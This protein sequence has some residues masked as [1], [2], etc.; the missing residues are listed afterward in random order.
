MLYFSDHKKYRIMKYI[1]KFLFVFTIILSCS[2]MAK[3]QMTWDKLSSEVLNGLDG[4]VHMPSITA[5]AFINGTTIYYV[6]D[7]E[8]VQEGDL[9]QYDGGLPAGWSS[10]TGAARWNDTTIMLFNGNEYALFDLD[11]VRIAYRGPFPN[12]PANVDAVSNWGDSQILFFSGSQYVIY[13]RDDQSV[14]QPA[15]ITDF[16]NY[17][18][19]T[20]DAVVNGDDGFIYFFR[21]GKFQALEMA[22]QSFGEVVSLVSSSGGLP[23][24]ASSGS[25]LPPVV[26]SG[27]VGRGTSVGFDDLP[28]EEKQRIRVSPQQSI[29]QAVH[30]SNSIDTSGWCLVGVPKGNSDSDL[31]SDETPVKGSDLGDSYEDD[32]EVGTRVAEIRVW[33]GRVVAALQTILQNE[34]GDLVELP[35]LGTK[36]GRMQSYKVPEGA[37]ITGVEGQFGGDYGRYIHNI[38][39][40]TS[41]GKSTRIGGPGRQGFKL[42]L[43]NSVSFFGFKVHHSGNISG[44][45]L[46]YVGYQDN[47]P[48][49]APEEEEVA[50]TSNSGSGKSFKEKFVG[51]YDDQHVDYLKSELIELQMGGAGESV[52][53]ELP[54]KDWM[55]KAVDYLTLDPLDIAKS[56]TK[57]TAIRLVAS[58]ERGGVKSDKVLPHGTH[59]TSMSG[60]SQKDDKSW[61]ESYSDF[62]TNFN[63]GVDVSVGTPVGGGS[64]SASYAQMNNT[65]MGREEIYYSR[66]SERK[67]FNLKMDLLFSDPVTGDRK[68]QLL[69]YDFR[70]MVDELPVPASAPKIRLS[71]YQ[72]GKRLP[73]QIERV[74]EAYMEVIK[75]Y[76]TH[77]IEEAD[78]GGKFSSYTVITKEDYENTRMTE[79]EFKAS[80]EAQIKAVNI[81]GGVEFGYGTKSI[82]GNKKG[83]LSVRNFVQGGNGEIFDTWNTSVSEN[84]VPVRVKLRPLSDLLS[85]EYWPQHSDI[86]KRQA[87]L[88]A[89][90]NQYLVDNDRGPVSDKRGK[91]FTDP[92][93]VDYT[94]TMTV[95]GI[96]CTAVND[97]KLDGAANVFGKINAGYNSDAGSENED[98]W[99]MTQASSV[100]IRKGGME[101]L[102]DKKE[103][104][105]SG[106]QKGEFFVTANFKD[107]LTNGMAGFGKFVGGIAKE[108]TG[109][110][111]SYGYN[112]IYIPFSEITETPKEYKL[113]G[114]NYDSTKLEILITVV[115]QPD[116]AKNDS[117]D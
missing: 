51:E 115:K 77:F 31:V 60:G 36:K 46:K 71:S 57:K 94:Y 7:D 92:K 32:T 113:G 6:S 114:F 27:S 3:A 35:I 93:A 76:G 72:K 53:L 89:V 13:D 78:F 43:D 58:E 45:A 62:T 90:I 67:L 4:G 109:D 23:P 106:D 70:R 100:D 108:I 14:S 42:R 37:C 80:A 117:D 24:V 28:N 97:N 107:A 19:G 39:F 95:T 16:G 98:I 8:G 74:R 99:R 52:R 103:V 41:D 33:G 91:F 81:G 85:P 56:P 82:V 18:L 5:T 65:R 69:D 79:T 12:I 20:P 68:R 30:E 111:A 88:L 54:A 38:T 104:V 116:Y 2:T 64:L 105:V 59:F 17:E 84:P 1:N 86:L 47:M 96:K 34:D 49:N 25:S 101:A 110:K 50:T 29:E 112:N 87:T 63:V 66:I 83:K 55:G 48:E 21:A 10:F 40:V 15:A 73:S 26:T 22:S 11:Q 61:V 75:K 44:I 9:S 102:G